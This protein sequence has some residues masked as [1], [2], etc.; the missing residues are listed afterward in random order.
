MPVLIHEFSRAFEIRNDPVYGWVSVGYS[1]TNPIFMESAPVP[2]VI[3]KAVEE[4]MFAINDNYRPH[5]GDYALIA[6]D[7]YD[8]DRTTSNFEDAYR[9]A[10]SVL[11]V[12]NCQRD[13]I[14][15]ETTG[16]RYFWLDRRKTAEWKFGKTKITVNNFLEIDGIKTLL[17][18]WWRYDK[19]TRLMF[20]ME[21]AGLRKYNSQGYEINS[22][23]KIF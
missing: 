5:P 17:T 13:E 18:W 20:S 4:E 23:D 19:N 14:G 12:A 2:E 10:Y 3:V 16:Y 15:R 1:I 9:N 8:I 21:E 6:R 7:L 22:S 11:A